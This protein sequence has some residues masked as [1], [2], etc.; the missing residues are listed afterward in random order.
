MSYSLDDSYEERNISSSPSQQDFLDLITQAQSHRYDNQRSPYPS[1]SITR[2]MDTDILSVDDQD[3]E[4]DTPTNHR[5][6]ILNEEGSTGYPDG[7]LNSSSSSS[8]NGNTI[9]PIHNHI[10]M[11]PP[12]SP[13]S[14][15]LRPNRRSVDALKKLLQTDEAPFPLIINPPDGG[16]WVQNGE[17]ES[18]RRDDGIWTAPEIDIE[19]FRLDTDN[20]ALMY[21]LH[22]VGR[23]HKNFYA[24]EGKLGPIVFSHMIDSD[25]SCDPL[26]R[27]ILRTE[28][29]TLYK[30]YPSAQLSRKLEPEE[31]LAIMSNNLMEGEPLR[32]EGLKRV[33]VPNA[34]ELIQKFDEHCVA[35]Q[36]KVGI[37]YQKFGQ[38]TE[39]EMFCNNDHSPAFK[40]FVEL[41]GETVTLKGFEKY[42]GGLDTCHDQTGEKSIYTEF[43]GQEIMFHVSTLLPYDACDRQQ[44]AR[45]RH[46]GNDIVLVVFQDQNTPYSPDCV[47]SRF[48][49][50]HIVV[51]V[52]Y[53]NTDHTVYKVAVAAKEDVPD[54]TPPLPT[55]AVFSKDDDFREWILT[56]ILNAEA[57]CYKAPDFRRLANRTRT[58]LFGHLLKDLS[59]CQEDIDAPPLS[60]TEKRK[61]VFVESSFDGTQSPRRRRMTLGTI[62]PRRKSTAM[63]SPKTTPRKTHINV[64]SNQM[65]SKPRKKFTAS[66]PDLSTILSEDSS[67]VSSSSQTMGHLQYKTKTEK[68]RKRFTLRKGKKSKRSFTTNIIDDLK[69]SQQIPG[70]YHPTSN[71]HFSPEMSSLASNLNWSVPNDLP[72]VILQTPQMENVPNSLENLVIPLG[73]PTNLDRVRCASNPDMMEI[74][75]HVKVRS[76]LPSD[77]L[78]ISDIQRSPGSAGPQT[79]D[80]CIQVDTKQMFTFPTPPNSLSPTLPPELSSLPHTLLHT[81]HRHPRKIA[82]GPDPHLH[83]L[84]SHHSSSS[85][86]DNRQ[87]GGSFPFVPEEDEN[88]DEEKELDDE[89]RDLFFGT[90]SAPDVNRDDQESSDSLDDLETDITYD[91]LL[92]T[93]QS[94]TKEIGR[95]QHE[96]LRIHEENT[97]LASKARKWKA[98]YR[99]A[100][101]T[102]AEKEKTI[103]SLQQ[104]LSESRER[105]PSEIG[106]KL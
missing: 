97:I 9:S 1:P 24:R 74:K 104:E 88:E 51:Q 50:A 61:S 77:F 59:N 78:P 12:G 84:P 56:K 87:S 36:H 85:S 7:S 38:A 15:S 68:G 62:F 41:L 23:N 48:L 54:F 42:R 21:G 64:E 31:Y 76:R 75:K 69:T 11:I 27:M 103:E 63:P 58:Q 29:E 96:Q 13:N 100:K 3:G 53:P 6:V 45:K 95:I 10:S 60:M 106:T 33:M 55:P 46:I 71:S 67:S 70:C 80:V 72:G 81:T 35:K 37:I 26:I 16:Y 17:Y 93:L 86:L 91:S 32:I 82:M 79:C 18:S 14:P 101:L 39:E 66:T 30:V 47:R 52:E 94:R 92:R 102:L 65:K 44:V 22:F 98:K 4:M 25:V 83:D 5:H 19:H 40:E 49:H 8:V 99:L 43:K 90:T 28:N 2:N 89:R 73:S 20:T 105:R 57:K 34:S